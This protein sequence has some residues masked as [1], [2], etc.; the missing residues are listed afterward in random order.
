ML[1]VLERVRKLGLNYW[2]GAAAAVILVL[3]VVQVARWTGAGTLGSELIR[4]SLRQ[5]A[6]SERSDV[7]D[8]EQYQAIVEKQHFGKKK[9][10]PGLPTF[11]GI[12]GESALFGSSPKDI[13]PYAVDAELPGGWK[14]VEIRLN[15][16]ELEKDGE[17]KTMTVFPELGAEPGPPVPQPSPGE[18]PAGPPV[19]VAGQE[20]A[21]E[22][23]EAGDGDEV[24]PPAISEQKPADAEEIRARMRERIGEVRRRS[25]R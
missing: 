7:R 21:E 16:V 15:S 20:Q 6:A 4:A 22:P 8:L 11:F 3:C 13:K 19:Q 14:L 25:G 2:L 10:P 5:A 9:P 24:E 12:L 18:A 17:T 23:S 1:E